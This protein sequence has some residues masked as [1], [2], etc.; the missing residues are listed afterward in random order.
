MKATILLLFAVLGN[1]FVL[2]QETSHPG[3]EWSY[4]GQQGPQKWGD[5]KP[6]YT[7]CK[8]GHQQ[9]PIDIRDAKKEPLPPIQFDYK[10]SV[11]KIINNGHTIQVN[12]QPGSFITVGD[13]R[14]QLKQFHFH[15]PSEEKIQGKPHAMVIHLVHADEDGQLAVIAVL[16]SGGTASPAIQKIWE[17]LPTTEGAEQ[18]VAG[19]EVNAESLLPPSRGY[20]TF[21]GSLTTPPCSE[22]VTWF[23][24]KTAV[25]ISEEQI[26]VFA[27][28]YPNNARPT[29]PS[30]GRTIRESEPERTATNH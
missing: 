3:H 18:S 6:E 7:T 19:V 10:T 5:L 23:V 30:N 15:H 26:G 29:Q 22:H 21:Q 27:K 28:V 20:Y 8:M 2:A 4:A 1:C 25:Q 9:S 13:K 24:L 17:N 12:Y 14:Y 11:L 16:L